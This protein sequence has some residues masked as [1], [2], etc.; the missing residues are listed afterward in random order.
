MI[1]KIVL[2]HQPCPSCPSS[3]AYCEYEDGHGF[4]YSCSKY[5]PSK[6]KEAFNTLDEIFTYEHLSHRGLTKDTLKFFDI[7]TKIDKDG[8][9]VS[10][11][12]KYPNGSYK[13]RN[14]EKKE[15]HTTGDIANA[16]LYGRDKF[17]AGS[18]KYVTITEGEY[19]A[20]SLYQVLR[21]PCV[22]VR[23]SSSAV[24]DCA[25]DR[26]WLQSFDRVY[27]AF[28]DD[29][30][31]RQAA[32]RV[33]KLFDYN[34]LYQVKFAPKK[35]ANEY[36]QADKAEELRNVW[37]NS[38]KYLP[39]SIVSAFSEFEEILKE[40]P[41]SSVAYPFKTLNDMTYGIRT[42][43]VVLLTAQEKVGKTSIM[44]AI[45]YHLL[46][47]TKDA[48]GAIYLE[49]PKRLHLQAL[50]GLE[51]RKPVHLP[52]C[53]VAEG[54]VLSAVKKLVGEDD[55][56]HVYSHFGSDDPDVLL[57][58]IRFLVSARSCRYVLL[59]HITMAVTGLAG[60]NNERRALEYLATRLAMMVRELDFS[61]IMV[62]HVNDYGQTRGSHYITKV[63]DITISAK[64]DTL[65]IDPVERNTIHLTIP[66]NRFAARSGPA[67]DLRMDELTYILREVFDETPANDNSRTVSHT[68]AA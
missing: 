57:D 65:H 39:E 68:R 1:N 23:S 18:H 42:G 59:D 56:L 9:P 24:S 20:A 19:D 8:K 43:E 44:H 5:F 46:K 26:A 35:D 27:L 14:L 66:Y 60:E 21:S 2:R 17:P 25:A 53:N 28:D 4:C 58:T 6:T 64:R 47:E 52:D 31:G 12:F 30:A 50:A 54:E 34:R 13:I 38:K 51:L 55:R 48:I 45:E 16:G 61:L 22:S 37:H 41:K 29:A 11:G 63:A 67:G 3:D 10:V 7:Q 32:R 40:K 33:A 15:Y 36:L 49:E 62:S